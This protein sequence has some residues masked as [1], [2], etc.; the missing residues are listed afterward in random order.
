MPEEIQTF[1]GAIQRSRS[2]AQIRFTEAEAESLIA[3]CY[4]VLRSPDEHPKVVE[5]WNNYV[6]MQPSIKKHLDT[7]DWS[8]TKGKALVLMSRLSLDIRTGI[9][10]FLP[11]PVA[12]TE[13]LS[14]EDKQGLWAWYLL[15]QG[16][17]IRPSDPYCLLYPCA[18][19]FMAGPYASIEINHRAAK[20]PL[21]FAAGMIGYFWKSEDGKIEGAE[22]T[23]IG[24]LKRIGGSAQ[25]K[26]PSTLRPKRDEGKTAKG[27]LDNK[28]GPLEEQVAETLLKD[29][30]RGTGEEIL[31][32]ALDGFLNVVPSA[33]ARDIIDRGKTKQAEL[34]RGIQFESDSEEIKIKIE[35][36]PAE[37]K[38]DSN[39]LEF[40]QRY[41]ER[42]HEFFVKYPEHR[43]PLYTRY[44]DLSQRK[45]AKREGVTDRAIKSAQ[46][47][48]RLI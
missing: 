12:E 36:Y 27:A 32:R 30:F 6:D 4:A 10:N 33:V 45:L 24:A 8:R 2:W 37:T 47:K 44:G 41:I 40:T 21:G 20:H 13:I 28:L 19:L 34:E 1:D 3:H 14:E 5:L 31:A 26:I 22:E 39:I 25:K 29:F 43:E 23:V 11:P 46:I 35:D 42:L 16:N 18:L 15:N 38:S 7:N 48:P 9:T 17:A